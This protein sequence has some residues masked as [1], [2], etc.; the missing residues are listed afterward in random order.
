MNKK[1][2]DRALHMAPLMDIMNIQCP[3]PFDFDVAREHREFVEFALVGTPVV[4]S[5]S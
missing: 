2:R 1:Q 4:D 5:D 3:E